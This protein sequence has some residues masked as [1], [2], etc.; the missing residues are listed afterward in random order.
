MI[1][2]TDLRQKN[3]QRTVIPGYAYQPLF[4]ALYQTQSQM[5]K[6]SGFFLPVAIYTGLNEQELSL[7]VGHDS[8]SEWFRG[9][10]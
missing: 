1:F 3:P 7:I 5:G 4:L 9:Q 6:S 10:G 2:G 8:E